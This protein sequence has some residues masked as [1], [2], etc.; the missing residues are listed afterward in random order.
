MLA[1]EQ[2]AWD[3]G[4][5]RVAGVDEAG[6]GPLAG[7][8]IAGAVFVA[9]DFL[10]AEAAGLLGGLTDSKQLSAR[11]RD[12]FLGLF[13]ERDE[14]EFAVGEAGVEEIDRLNI[15][16]ATHLAM[17]RAVEALPVRPDHVLVDGLPVGGL[18]V[19]STA[20]IGGD[21]TSLLIAAASVVAKTARD[22]I[23]EALAAEFPRYGWERNKGYGTPAHLEALRAHGPTPHHRRSFGP[24][25][26]LQLDFR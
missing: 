22:R 23:M 8:V 2:Q 7:P 1:H 16:R 17:R 19:P 24:V 15:L 25:R 18:P 9:P 26:Q 6:R 4:W 10:R 20:I 14:I 3:A 11:A 21:G 13:G 5:V 12:A